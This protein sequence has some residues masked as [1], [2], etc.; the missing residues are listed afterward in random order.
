MGSS[1]ACEVGKQ[2]VWPVDNSGALG[3]VHVVVG[4]VCGLLASLL[5]L[6][7]MVVVE[8]CCEVTNCFGALCVLCSSG[9]H[10]NGGTSLAGLLTRGCAGGE[11]SGGY[12]HW[13]SLTG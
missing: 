12:C 10:S 13:S 6:P 1:P 9:G 5:V 2:G 4:G 8:K 3:H 11:L 7:E